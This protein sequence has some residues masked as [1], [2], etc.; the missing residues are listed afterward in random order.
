MTDASGWVLID[1][2]IT[3][4]QNDTG[5]SR[6]VATGRNGGCPI[7]SLEPW[8]Y[9]LEADRRGPANSRHI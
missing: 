9:E 7:A 2:G 4:R 6:R 3:V 5:V 1:A 8:T